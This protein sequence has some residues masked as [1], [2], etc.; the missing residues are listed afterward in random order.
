MTHTEALAEIALD[1]LVASFGWEHRP[2]VTRALRRLFSKPARAFAQQM[3]EFDA[4]MGRLGLPEAAR[5]TQRHY[6]RDVRVFSEHLLPKGPFLALANHP[7]MTDTLSLFAA[8][9]R[10][11]LKII[12]L[13]RP[14]LNSLP[15]TSKRLFY[16]RQED[17]ASRA[18]LV[19]R[20]GSHLRNGGAALTFPAGHIEPDPEVHDGV[21]ESLQ[22]WTDSVGVF[23]R[24]APETPVVPV[25]VRG[26]VWRNAA[27]Q[28]F[29]YVK[30]T[31]E[32][33]E[34]LA[35]TFQLLA[36]VVCHVKPVTV[37]VQIGRPIAAK[38]LGTTDPRAIHEAVLAEMTRLYSL[39]APQ[40][41]P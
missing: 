25:L 26:V 3:V 17:S 40:P 2:L 28:S 7:G 29:G 33:R 14:F 12:A 11:D 34:K 22:T 13:E 30:R 37:R 6:V 27:L 36:H 20:V 9:N 15:H 4:N 35:A 18:A 10:E 38:T 5:R 8:L 32:E 1:D 24:V 21:L 41:A 39:H 31:R 16:V 23:I 19:R